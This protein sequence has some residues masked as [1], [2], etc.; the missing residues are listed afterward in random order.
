[1]ILPI[2]AYGTPVLRTVAK[3]ITPD[4]PNLEKLMADMWET[5]YASSGRRFGSATGE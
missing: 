3:E 4:Y 5:L 1:M 2:V